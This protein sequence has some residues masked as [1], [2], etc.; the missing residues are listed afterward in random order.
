MTI[1]TDK[2]VSGSSLILLLD[3][4]F[5]RL[6]IVECSWCDHVF[7]GVAWNCN[8]SISMAFQLL[9]YFSWLQIPKVDTFVLWTAD[10]I[11]AI[12]DRKCRW[13][14]VLCVNMA[15]VCLQK[16]SSWE[17]PEPLLKTNNAW[18]VS[19]KLSLIHQS[20]LLHTCGNKIGR[21]FILTHSWIQHSVH[22]HLRAYLRYV[23]YH[24]L[25]PKSILK[26]EAMNWKWAEVRS[27]ISNTSMI[28]N[29]HGI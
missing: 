9:H 22:S 10:N 3:P 29:A 13:N 12:R 26:H 23:A 27:K 6:V 5:H 15:S 7:P 4:D 21:C 28:L 25:V 16:L 1:E 8:D 20:R 2:R 24:H 11:L 17:I 19:H 14:A 18:A